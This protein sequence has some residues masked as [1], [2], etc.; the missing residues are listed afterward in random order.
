M[1]EIIASVPGIGNT[2][3]HSIHF[4]LPEMGKLNHRQIAALVGV[5]P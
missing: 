1:L 2:T 4:C 3:A 5:A